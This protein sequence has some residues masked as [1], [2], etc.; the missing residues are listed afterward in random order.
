MGEKADKVNNKNVQNVEVKTL[1]EIKETT[2][3]TEITENLLLLS[4]CKLIIFSYAFIPSLI[5]QL[6][7]CRTLL[8][9]ES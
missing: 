9:S 1:S 7:N 6:W 5:K 3:I 2:E 4:I 8:N